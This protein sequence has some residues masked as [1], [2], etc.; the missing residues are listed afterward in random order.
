MRGSAAL[1]AGARRQL[2]ERGAQHCGAAFSAPDTMPAGRWGLEYAGH[3][4]NPATPPQVQP[5]ES[6]ELAVVAKRQSEPSLRAPGRLGLCLLL[7]VRFAEAALRAQDDDT[8]GP[9]LDRTIDVIEQREHSVVPPGV[10]PVR[11]KAACFGSWFDGFAKPPFTDQL[12]CALVR[13]LRFVVL[14]HEP[15]LAEVLTL[16][17]YLK[18]GF[19]ARLIRVNRS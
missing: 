15:R 18:Y 2:A 16:A 5:T 7:L 1:A 14:C 13:G 4:V 10:S 11:A 8:L 3:V 9:V 6:A 19:S 12:T 17:S